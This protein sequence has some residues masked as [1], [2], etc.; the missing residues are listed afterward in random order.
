MSLAIEITTNVVGCTVHCPI[1]PQDLLV[2][3]YQS[4]KKQLSLDD[5]ERCLCRIPNINEIG[6]S[7]FSEPFL[8]PDCSRMISLTSDMGFHSILLTTLVGF[9]KKDVSIMPRDGIHYIRF[10][11]PDTEYCRMNEDEWIAKHKMFW[12]MAIPAQ[13]DHFTMGPVSDKVKG[14]LASIGVTD[15]L[16]M[17]L[18]SRAGAVHP[19]TPKT[20]ELFCVQQRW[21]RNVIMPNG[22]VYLCCMDMG[23]E[24]QL[25][26]L[27]V[28]SY[29]EIYDQAE[30]L[31]VDDHANM[32]CSKCEYSVHGHWI[33]PFG[34]PQ[35]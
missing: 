8:N 27:L 2:S 30:K 29:Q 33:N 10:H 19:V 5:F 7:G 25:G 35:L 3:R 18:I 16:G 23:L 11:C 24:H 4:D 6:F 22:D 20:G 32:I 17:H 13:Y 15:L 21:H 31:M 28:D 9:T 1:C 14:Y 26:N 12:K 34:R